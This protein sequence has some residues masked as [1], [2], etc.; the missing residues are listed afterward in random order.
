MAFFVVLNEICQ[1]G[2]NIEEIMKKLEYLSNKFTV[3]FYININCYE[4]DIPKEFKEYIA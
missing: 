2:E 3:D 4:K 1:S